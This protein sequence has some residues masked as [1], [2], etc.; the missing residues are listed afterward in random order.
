MTP[1]ILVALPAAGLRAKGERIL[2]ERMRKAIVERLS[3]D[4]PTK[5]PS[6]NSEQILT[7]SRLDAA[8]SRRIHG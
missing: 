5:P 3:H 4:A 1:R 6:R 2:Q 7:N 8:A